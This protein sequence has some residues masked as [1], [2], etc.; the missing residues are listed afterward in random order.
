MEDNKQICAHNYSR[1]AMYFERFSVAL[2]NFLKAL[3][4]KHLLVTKA[5]FLRK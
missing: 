5:S 4:A 1:T 2:G 3:C